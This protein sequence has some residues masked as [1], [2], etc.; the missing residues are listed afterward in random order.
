MNEETSAVVMELAG[1]LMRCC[2]NAQSDPAWE[3]AFYRFEGES[4]WCRTNGVQVAGS[5]VE[6]LDAPSSMQKNGEKLRGL[7]GK[8]QCLFLLEVDA[9]ARYN[10]KFDFE[11]MKRW[12]I[13]KQ[14]GASGLPVDD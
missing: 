12:K 5:E 9:N 11:N 13:S 8:D 1:D 4:S 2:D 14:N 3:R 10:I 7:L 6:F